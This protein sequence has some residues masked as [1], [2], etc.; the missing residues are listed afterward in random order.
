[1]NKQIYY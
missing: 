1:V